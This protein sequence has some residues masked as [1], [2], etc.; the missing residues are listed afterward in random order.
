[1]NSRQKFTVTCEKNSFPAPTIRKTKPGPASYAIITTI[2]EVSDT[3]LED[4]EP[5]Y[6][7]IDPDALDQFF[8]SL[9]DEQQRGVEVSLSY[10][11]YDVTITQAG[12]QAITRRNSTIAHE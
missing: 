10:N 11:R 2:G 8:R 9:Q 12:E 5:L 1:M 7:F 6:S 4:I 3:G